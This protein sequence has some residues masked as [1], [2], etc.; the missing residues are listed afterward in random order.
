MWKMLL[1]MAFGFIR[2]FLLPMVKLHPAHYALADFTVTLGDKVVGVYTDGD[3]NN[4]PQLERLWN[5]SCEELLVLGVRGTAA[6]VKKD[7][8]AKQR[9]LALLS[10]AIDEIME[11]DASTVS[12][13]VSQQDSFNAQL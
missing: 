11:D 5:E 2:K 4:G 9:V 8:A 13:M 6:L 1:P 3:K 10:E 7:S 12:K